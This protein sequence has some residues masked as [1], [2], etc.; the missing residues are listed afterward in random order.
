MR[1]QSVLLSVVAGAL[2]LAWALPAVAAG[3]E[4]TI[5]GM[6]KCTKCSLKETEKCGTAIEV[7][8]KNGKTVLYYLVDNDVSKG[9]HDKICKEPKKVTATGTLEKVD[10]KRELTVTKIDLVP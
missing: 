5:T 4:V 8:G 6:A 9:F 3:K 7:E 10:K 1:K 2:L